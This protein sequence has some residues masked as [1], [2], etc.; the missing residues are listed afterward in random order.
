[1]GSSGL[2]LAWEYIAGEFPLNPA[3]SPEWGEVTFD[4]LPAAEK[5]KIF[6]Y[7]F[8]VRTL[9]E[10]PEGQ[11]GISLCGLTEMLLH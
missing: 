5:Q 2:G 1:M 4:E 6:R 9:P 3:D 11:I 8:V 10:M 7:K